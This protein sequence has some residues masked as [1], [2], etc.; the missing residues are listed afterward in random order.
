MGPPEGFVSDSATSELSGTISAS[1]LHA[2]ERSTRAEAALAA[3][4][5]QCRALG[6]RLTPIRRQV[7]ATLYGTHRP[8]GAYDL[9]EQLAPKGRRLAPITV[10][11]A[12]D[13]LI[14]QH[15]VHRLAS[16]NAYV[17][18]PHG[19]GDAT[20]I[21]FLICESCGGVDEIVSP[22]IAHAVSEILSAERFHSRKTTIEITGSCVH[23]SDGRAVA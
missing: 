7:L 13:F 9:A 1:C 12:L 22:S 21:A 18:C 16:R 6:V 2:A 4:E 19:H 10:Y 11:R 17:A 14:E 8:L 20:P 5:A 15:L 3:A 23:C